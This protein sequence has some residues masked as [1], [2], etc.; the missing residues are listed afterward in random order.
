MSLNYS[1]VLN[2]S[3]NSNNSTKILTLG[4]YG[5]VLIPTKDIAAIRGSGKW[6]PPPRWEQSTN[7][8][9]AMIDAYPMYLSGK[10]PNVGGPGAGPSPASVDDNFYSITTNTPSDAGDTLRKSIYQVGS[11]GLYSQPPS[12]WTRKEFEGAENQYTE[13]ALKALAQGGMTPTPF[14]LYFFSNTNVKYLQDRMKQEV[15]RL[16]G[17]SI[18]DQSIDE[19]LIIMRNKMIYAYSG[20]LP[21][22]ESADGKGLNT[23]TGRGEKSCSLESRLTRLNKSVLEEIIKQVLSGINQYKT[24]I[25]DKGSMPMPLSLPINTSMAGSKQLSESIGFNSGLQNTIA[26][27]SFNQRYNII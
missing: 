8:G 17:E 27:Q 23:I 2:N 24:Y 15:L 26:A 25:K 5:N 21:S 1:N 7:R 3:N 4:N 13:W 19:L 11:T 22:T 6:N 10:W 9:N 20:W 16:T 12:A 18:N 14:V